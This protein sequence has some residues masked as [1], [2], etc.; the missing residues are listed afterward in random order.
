MKW[1]AINLVPTIKGIH[2][3]TRNATIEKKM[4]KEVALI[5]KQKRGAIVEGAGLVW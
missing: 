4:K 5:L 1:L 2:K 3:C